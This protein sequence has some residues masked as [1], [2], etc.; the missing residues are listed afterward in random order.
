MPEHPA[1]TVV[2]T[3]IRCGIDLTDEVRD[4]LTA[5]D[6]VFFI[7]SDPVWRA[8]MYALR[9]DAISLAS[10]YGENVPR[11]ETYAAIVERVLGPVRA[12][13]RVCF[14]VPGHPAVFAQPTHEAIRRARAEGFDAVM[15]PALSAA[16]HLYADL[17]VD[18]GEAGSMSCDA[19]DFLIFGRRADPTMALFLWQIDAIGELCEFARP[20]RHGLEVLAEVLL[21][22]LPAS[23][24][25]VVYEAASYAITDP[26]IVRIR[27]A[28]LASAPVSI[29]ST[30]YVPA[31]QTP[32][33]VAERLARLGLTIASS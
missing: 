5:A 2:G 20:N 33:P 3:G 6:D 1:L 8:S 25:V 23:H 27:L 13:R 15:L 31:A 26:S 18:P 32:S 11:L 7:A 17:G 29:F 19:T 9:A 10:L 14:A 12:G 28:E 24:E 16:D 4:V 22:T 21:E 30:L